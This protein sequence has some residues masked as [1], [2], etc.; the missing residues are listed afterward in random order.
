MVL[1]P[2]RGFDVETKAAHD[3]LAQGKDTHTVDS[4]ASGHGDAA[5][6]ALANW[7][8]ADCPMR[9]TVQWLSDSAGLSP[10]ER[11]IFELAVAMRVFPPVKKA[12]E[13]WGVL[14][15]G[16]LPYALSAVLNV[17]LAD[18]MAACHPKGALWTSGV[19]RINRH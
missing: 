5:K 11:A 10:V 13:T 14:N 9:M 4:A 1:G 16:D 15:R 12:V 8:I 2:L 6:A 19:V 18:A 17:P 3:P 7:P